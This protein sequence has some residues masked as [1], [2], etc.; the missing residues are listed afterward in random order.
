MR[1]G[2]LKDVQVSNDWDEKESDT[3]HDGW[4]ENVVSIWTRRGYVVNG[5]SF[6]VEEMKTRR[7]N[8]SISWGGRHYDDG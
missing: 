5:Y 1:H 4:R 8:G 7:L 6:K 2:G 3:H